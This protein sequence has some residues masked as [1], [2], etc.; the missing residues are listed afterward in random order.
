MAGQARTLLY[1][2]FLFNMFKGQTYAPKLKQ[3]FKSCSVKHSLIFFLN[4]CLLVLSAANLAQ[5]KAQVK[6]YLKPV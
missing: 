5:M 3:V 6:T 4:R 1:R 2:N